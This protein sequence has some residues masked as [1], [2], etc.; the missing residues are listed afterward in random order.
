MIDRIRVS[1]LLQIGLLLTFL[2]PFLQGG[3]SPTEGNIS[4]KIAD[5]T[6]ILDSIAAIA[7][8]AKRINDSIDAAKQNSIS[9]YK[10]DTI[11]NS[12]QANLEDNTIT[13][14]LS[15]KSRILKIFLRPNDN[16]SGLAL[17]IELFSI[18]ISEFGI[19]LAFILWTISLIIKFKDFN[20]IFNLLNIIGLVSLYFYD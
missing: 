6:R 8:E 2:L 15:M 4:S 11:G 14:K 19:V 16:Y 18:F 12:K 9:I 17:V 20:G 3:C 7:A 5:S 10:K 1:R 13:D